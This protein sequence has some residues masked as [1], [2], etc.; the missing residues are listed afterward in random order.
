MLLVYGTGVLAAAAFGKVAPAIPL[1]RA[2]LGLSLGRAGW[3]VSAIT[4]VAA[5]LGT[6]VG[7]WVRRRGGRRVLLAGLATSR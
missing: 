3:L 5:L 7:L 6:P 4:A 2:D 1:L